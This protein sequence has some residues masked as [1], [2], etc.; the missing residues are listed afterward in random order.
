[1]SWYFQIAGGAP[2]LFSLYGAS[3]LRRTVSSQ[4]A[5]VFSF[6]VDGATA[7]SDAFASERQICSVWYGDTGPSVC[8]FTG[9]LYRLPRKGSGPAESIDYE[10]RDCW[11]DFEQNVFQ[12][13]W[14]VI[15]GHDESGN[16]TIA[17]EYRSEC[18]LGMD[19]TGDA[20]NS[21]EQIGAIVEWAISVGAYCQIGDI[22]VSA[23]VPFDEI[24]DL[25]C[26]EC[27]K[28]MVRWTPD[29]VAW[30]DY[31]TLPPTFNVTRRADCE[32]AYLAFA[33]EPEELNINS[34]PYLMPP[35][36]VIRFIEITNSNDGSADV[37]V[38][39]DDYPTG[40]SGTEY[41]AMVMT[42]RLAEGQSTYQKQPIK[43]Q[44][45]IP[46]ANSAG[47]DDDDGG[48]SSGGPSDDPTILWWQRKV[49]WLSNL[50]T[51]GGTYSP[52]D[53][54]DQLVITN[55][56]GVFDVGEGDDDG[57]G[58]VSVVDGD[59][60]NADYANELLQGT[61][62]DW[63]NVNVAK[64]SWS[65]LVKY[66]YPS[67]ISA[68]SSQD[69][70]AVNVFG[71]DDGSGYSTPVCV[72]TKATATN[73]VTSTYSQMTGYTSPEPPA[74]GLAET[75]FESVGTLQ[76]EGQYTTISSEVGYWRLGLVLNIAGGRE[77]W[78][79]MNALLQEIEDDLDLGRTTL[80]FGP[81]GHLTLQDLME[82]LRANRTRATSSHI[83][84]RQSGTADDV[85][86]VDGPTQG[87]SDGGGIPPDQGPPWEGYKFEQGDDTDKQPNPPTYDVVIGYGSS[88]IVSD[89]GGG[90]PHPQ[91]IEQFEIDA[92]NTGDGATY[93]DGGYDLTTLYNALSII[94]GD[95]DY[96]NDQIWI[97]ATDSGGDGGSV[98]ISPCDPSI[99]L[100]PNLNPSD[101]TD[102]DQYIHIDLNDQLIE[103]QDA[104]G[105]SFS[106]T[107]NGNAS[108]NLTG[109]DG[110]AIYLDTDDL[111]GKTASF[112]SCS[113]CVDGVMK[114][115][116]VLMTDPS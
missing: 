5:S 88:S 78:A 100:S 99:H 22:A 42:C 51:P 55:V 94:T 34:L 58:T 1:M 61:V 27:I 75:L 71:P 20:L 48:D 79:T 25:P 76:Y 101:D 97:G 30:F 21:G 103:M 46:I 102:D 60:I 12:Q 16:P 112:Q 53:I 28:K 86:S 89:G 113:V 38:I 92:G 77:E 49:P 32:A 9:R 90:L 2:Q 45:P 11:L 98:I 44:A 82:Q 74:V 35:G 8:F 13:Q 62:A 17:A 116:L 26:S 95:S 114:S 41:G 3:R 111:S 72:T 106:V 40:T 18:I 65:A 33:R 23:P 105:N 81:A 19:L 7:D 85:T 43:V 70:D 59:T 67:D 57:S 66:S 52:S 4:N 108:L 37:E 80:K 107:T 56:Y 110:G 31:S 54:A 83:K 115:A 29:A 6:T 64:T 109:S 96:H 104:S 14:N 87:H 93:P 84:E 73:A 91:A 15:T 24:T 47:S 10:L 69:W 50:G 63:M 68:Y 36:V 39:V